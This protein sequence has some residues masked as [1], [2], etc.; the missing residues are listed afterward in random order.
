MFG[1][2]SGD[3]KRV[4]TTTRLYRK[5]EVI[6]DPRHEFYIDHRAAKGD[7]EPSAVKNS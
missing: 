7:L 1:D 5:P 2:F 3:W 4:Q 6:E